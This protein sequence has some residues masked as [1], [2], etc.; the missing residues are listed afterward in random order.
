MKLIFMEYLA[1]LKERDELDVI[2]PD[3]LS[4]VGFTVISRPGIG[5]KQY[6]VDVAAIG[7]GPDGART[8][9]LLSIKPGDLRRSGWDA[10]VQSLRSSLNQILDVYIGNH[11][12]K[13]YAH[14]PVVIVLCLG[15]DL[16]E[17]VRADVEGF[18]ALNTQ[19]RVKFDLWNGDRLAELL[20]SGILRENALPS[21]WQ[22]DLR[23]SVAMVDEPEV[24][25]AHYYRFATRIADHC[26]ANR[27]SRLTAIRQ[28]Y[29]ALWTLYVWAR[30]ADNIEAAYLCS[31]RAVLI[32]WSLIKG[33]LTGKSRAARQLE[34]TFTRLIALHN[35][36]ADDYLSTYVIPRARIPH[37]LASAVP[38]QSSL[39]VNLRLFKII[40]RIGT[41]GLW[42]LH[43]AHRIGLEGKRE[44]R[45]AI[46]AELKAT[47]DLLA[48]VLQNNPVLCTPIKDS[49]AIDINIAC[50]FLNRV[51]CDQVVQ[52]WI[53]QI[54][55]ATIFAYHSN[56][57][58]PC[59]FNDYRDLIDH[60]KDDD[61]YRAEATVGSLLVPTV[62]VWASIAG[63]VET[64]GCLADFASG[65]Y[66]HSTLQL[67]YPGP[68][69]EE[70][71][72]RGSGRH[73]LAGHDIRIERRPQ[74]MLAPIRSECTMSAAFSSL[75]PLACG[76]W[77]LLILASRHHGIPVPPHFWPL[78]A[79][80][81]T[82]GR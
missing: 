70:H 32:S 64:L 60:P 57:P 5:T 69:T 67:W 42:Q 2:M 78:T 75:S 10:G 19:G 7:A 16:H 37:G 30:A 17:D 11:V 61:E 15:G 80:T 8:L 56:G 27:P 54:A 31:E 4:E 14:L 34:Q 62:A 74:D 3:L 29:V 53:Q 76:L 41:R 39:D 72:Y 48:D 25:I 50:L 24:S 79:N 52:N 45:E 59:V 38:S 73:G 22:S 51:G 33:Y 82:V 21:T 55:G 9:F 58:Y 49:Q 13:R 43:L 26:K 23:K 66:Q 47:A 63:D 12:P 1:S 28:I 6:G 46:Q 65:P 35:A 40:G 20:L 71:L 68:D 18:M 36:V 77:P 44:D 81:I